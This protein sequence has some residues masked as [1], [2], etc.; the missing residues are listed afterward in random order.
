MMPLLNSIDDG[1]C[2]VLSG[3]CANALCKRNIAGGN[4]SLW[5]GSALFEYKCNSV[6]GICK[7]WGY[8]E[9][10]PNPEYGI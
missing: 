3:C 1:I 4:N 7:D 2:K 5:V 8:K 9:N 10:N 6:L